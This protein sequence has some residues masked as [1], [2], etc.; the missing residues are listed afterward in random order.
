ML[1]LLSQAELPSDHRLL[2]AGVSHNL[3]SNSLVL[4]NTCRSHRETKEQDIYSANHLEH[5]N[6]HRRC[7]R[8]LMLGHPL[9]TEAMTMLGDSSH[10]LKKDSGQKKGH[11]RHMMH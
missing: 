1:K 10:M 7:V 8:D 5:I 6:M 9:Q 4:P 11:Y 3:H 2:S